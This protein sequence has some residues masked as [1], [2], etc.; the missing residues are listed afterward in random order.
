MVQEMIAQEREF[1]KLILRSRKLMGFSL[2]KLAEETGREVT[3]SYIN[4]LE[5]SQMKNPSFEVVCQLTRALNME[6]EDVYEAFGHQDLIKRYEKVDVRLEDP[7]LQAKTEAFP[8]LKG[9][10]ESSFSL[11]DQ[12][13]STAINYSKQKKDPFTV[14]QEL[15]VV[16]EALKSNR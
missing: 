3:P 11:I 15:M 1:G 10:S 14:M 16:L 6:L 13:I 12:L 2:D 4:R 5:K 9:I 8:A 7:I